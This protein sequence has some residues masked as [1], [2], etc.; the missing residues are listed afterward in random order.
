MKTSL[1]FHIFL[2]F[3]LSYF[4]AA[5]LPAHAQSVSIIGG[6]SLQQLTTQ[7]PAS[8]QLVTGIEA[9][10]NTITV[11]DLTKEKLPVQKKLIYD[12]DRLSLPG[13]QRK[14]LLASFTHSNGTITALYKTGD[15]ELG[16]SQIGNALESTTLLHRA[17]GNAIEFS[18]EF[19]RNNATSFLG[20][21]LSSGV[22]DGQKITV[23]GTLDVEGKTNG[24]LTYGGT[25]EMELFRIFQTSKEDVSI[26][27]TFHGKDR[28]V[29]QVG[30]TKVVRE[31]VSATASPAYTSTSLSV[32][33]DS[34][35]L[36]LIEKPLIK[37]QAR[38]KKS[39]PDK[40]EFSIHYR[41]HTDGT[42]VATGELRLGE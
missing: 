31:V 21:T 11:L 1:P 35:E 36:V 20:Y 28:L 19:F 12:C 39:R 7:L 42:F 17:D 40:A 13:K 37:P 5:P 27:Q 23:R 4:L 34:S 24:P 9:D 16:I 3:P 30:F 22:E 33:S 2:S 14:E 6:K 41:Q 29:K 15:S 25:R 32:A 18:I 38:R 8:Y 26:Q 10:A